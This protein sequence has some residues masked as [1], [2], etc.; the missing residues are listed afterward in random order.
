MEDPKEEER[1]WMKRKVDASSSEDAVLPKYPR[2]PK[3]PRSP[4]PPRSPKLLGSPAS[5]PPSAFVI[6]SFRINYPWINIQSM[7]EN[8]GKFSC[9]EFMDIDALSC[10][11]EYIFFSMEGNKDT[12]Y[13]REGFTLSGERTSRPL[14]LSFFASLCT[15]SKAFWSFK[16]M[17]K[18]LK[19]RRDDQKQKEE[20]KQ[21][22]KQMEKSSDE[23][24]STHLQVSNNTDQDSPDSA[25]STEGVIYN[26]EVK[27]GRGFADIMI[28]GFNKQFLRENGL[29]PIGQKTVMKAFLAGKLRTTSVIEL[30]DD[31]V[32]LILF[33]LIFKLSLIL[34][35]SL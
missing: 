21:G 7:E 20:V 1:K 16:K 19:Q 33:T 27:S 31:S 30:K 14:H 28:T 26:H 6:K 5:P 13:G 9:T 15:L 23:V 12:W 17:K 3:T 4:K 18:E 10:F 22:Q 8:M 25:S 11:M 2:S 24:I 29:D 32:S 35:F 34:N